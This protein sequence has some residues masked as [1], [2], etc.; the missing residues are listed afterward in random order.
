LIIDP[1]F[2]LGT[3]AA[4]GGWT[5]FNGAVLN[6]TGHVLGGTKSCRLPAGN[7]VGAYEGPINPN[8]TNIT[9]GMQFDLTGF[10]Y[11]TNTMTS[12]FVGIQAT[13]FGPFNGSGVW[14]NLGTVETSFGVAKFSNH[15]DVNSALNTWIPLDTGVFTAPQY[16]Q[17]IDVYTLTVNPGSTGGSV[18]ID[19]LDLEAVPEPSTMMLGAMGVGLPLLMMRRRRS[20]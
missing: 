12:G 13:F 1:G 14:T 6:S 17:A 11:V 19:S 4:S 16:A 9:A 5:S 10:G 2:D 7:G 20:R 18:W 15:L 8:L 3:S